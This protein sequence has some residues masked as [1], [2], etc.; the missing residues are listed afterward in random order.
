MSKRC[1]PAR[2]LDIPETGRRCQK[3][4]SSYKTTSVPRVRRFDAQ[5]RRVE[6]GL[7]PWTQL[8]RSLPLCC[9]FYQVSTGLY[10]FFSRP[11]YSAVGCICC[12][13][14]VTDI[15]PLRIQIL[16]LSSSVRVVFVR[17]KTFSNWLT[18]T[19][20]IWLP[21]WY[22][23]QVRSLAYRQGQGSVRVKNTLVNSNAIA[24]FSQRQHTWSGIQHDAAKLSALS[25]SCKTLCRC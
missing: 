10:S 1:W 23:T 17:C 12:A 16:V 9:E 24:A 4:A 20:I 19:W 11:C 15:L 25:P 22:C 14:K 13:S 21:W 18:T 8:P 2:Q 5:A 7:L 3:T 6:L